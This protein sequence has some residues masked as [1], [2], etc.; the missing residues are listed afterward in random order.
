MKQNPLNGDSL[1]A[2]QRLGLPNQKLVVLSTPHR[3]CWFSSKF[4]GNAPQIHP[5]I[6]MVSFKGSPRSFPTPGRS[7]PYLSHQKKKEHPSN[8][9]KQENTGAFF[10]AHLSKEIPSKKQDNAA[11]CFC[12]L[13]CRGTIRRNIKEKHQNQRLD[14][15]FG[16]P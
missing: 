14:F 16:F 2:V 5:Y 4:R 1:P 12:W 9:K 7:F 13:T 10:P 15:R 3:K 8:Q 6:A 11:A